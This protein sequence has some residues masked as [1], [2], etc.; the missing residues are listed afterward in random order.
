MH[1]HD[2]LSDFIQ[3]DENLF[4]RKRLFF[5]YFLLY[6]VFQSEFISILGDV[7][8]SRQGAQ[9]FVLFDFDMFDV[10]NVEMLSASSPCESVTNF[11]ER[12][13][14]AENHRVE[15]VLSGKRIGIG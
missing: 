14:V 6:E 9:V 15:R 7:N 12:E 4:F 11:I 5:G 10:K 2:G 8:F 1:P 13:I 3:K